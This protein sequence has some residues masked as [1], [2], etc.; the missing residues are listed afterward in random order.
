M[1]QTEW[2]N[3][4]PQV[5]VKR[6]MQHSAACFTAVPHIQTGPYGTISASTAQKLT[7]LLPGTLDS[8]SDA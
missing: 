8:N 4:Y 2:D 1:L 6:T 5:Q 3:Q 7:L